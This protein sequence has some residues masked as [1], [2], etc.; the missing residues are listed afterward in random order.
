MRV[1]FPGCVWN[2]SDE[3]FSDR[4]KSIALVSTEAGGLKV[5]T[6]QLPFHSIGGRLDSLSLHAIPVP[7]HEA[8]HPC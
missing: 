8:M 1:I 7:K 3:A 4:G 6:S 5:R 2:Q